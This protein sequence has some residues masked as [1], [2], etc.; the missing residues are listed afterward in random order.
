MLIQSVK[1]K[2]AARA[3]AHAAE[4]QK[5]GNLACHGKQQICESRYSDAKKII[6]SF[7]TFICI[8]CD[9]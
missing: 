7:S 9:F 4:R 3:A 8:R 5:T 6:Y 1:V 2:N